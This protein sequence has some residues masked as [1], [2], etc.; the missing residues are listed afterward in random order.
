MQDKKFIVSLI[1]GIAI[2]I[3]GVVV[4]T[5]LFTTLIS[6]FVHF[7]LTLVKLNK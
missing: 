6:L 2:M 1:S 4:V 5:S 3:A 7:F